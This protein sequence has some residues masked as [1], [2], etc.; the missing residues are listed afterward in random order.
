MLGAV[1]KDKRQTSQSNEAVYIIYV[2]AVEH[3]I[4]SFND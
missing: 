1:K 3:L 4:V 2:F